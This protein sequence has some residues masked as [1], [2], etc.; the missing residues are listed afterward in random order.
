MA[1]D[2]RLEEKV[3][4]G[5]FQF[6]VM[7]SNYWS[8]LLSSIQFFSD[9][10]QTQVTPSGGTVKVMLSSDGVNYSSVPNGSFAA[11]DAYNPDR[12]KPNAFGQA[13]HARLTLSGIS[14]ATH[15]RA[16]ISRTA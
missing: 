16:V 14:G 6:P 4:D 3:A 7:N 5:D 12:T 10:Y 15:F 9:E 2:Y 1:R 11:L 8:M 13:S